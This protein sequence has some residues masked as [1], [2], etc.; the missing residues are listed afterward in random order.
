MEIND[1]HHPSHNKFLNQ[2]SEN[3]QNIQFN[4][5]QSLYTFTLSS[6]QTLE[7]S[8]GTRQ[9]P[10]TLTVDKGKRMNLTLWNFHRHEDLKVTNNEYHHYL[11][12]H[13]FQFRDP[14]LNLDTKPFKTS[15]NCH[16]IASVQENKQALKFISACED[17]PR[18]H[19]VHVSK[20]ESILVEILTAPLSF[21]HYVLQVEGLQHMFQ[22][23]VL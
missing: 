1:G 15:Q 20:S 11:S 4:N 12:Q 23:I 5:Y 14:K 6:L 7:T 22:I 2:P 3:I 16:Q 21:M 18:Q 8:L 19:S 13:T 17:G 10:W 9:C